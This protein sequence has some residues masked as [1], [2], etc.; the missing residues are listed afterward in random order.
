M[1][2]YLAQRDVDNFGSE[3]VD[4]AQRAAA[5][6][7]TPELQRLRDENQPLQDQL[8]STAKVAI[9]QALDAAVPNWREINQ[10][11]EFHRWLLLPD[12]LS[13]VVRDR[14]LKDAVAAADAPRVINFFRGFLA[15]GGAAPRPA[16]QASNRA[17]A[18]PSGQRTYTSEQ[19]RAL[20]S[21]YRRGQISEER[22]QKISADIVAAG[23]EGRILG[24][25]P[26]LTK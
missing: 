14:L 24:V 10:S 15:Q 25:G 26:Y 22:Y 12:V 2:D 8:N 9:D 23:R 13:G 5:H 19:I 18:A 7:L 17:R 3:M 21:A 11:E 4:L 1:A 6:A 16:G 20:S